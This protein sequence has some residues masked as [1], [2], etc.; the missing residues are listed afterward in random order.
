MSFKKDS[1]GLTKD[2][3]AASLI[4]LKN[5]RIEVAVTD[6]GASLVAIKVPD[7]EGVLTDI[8]LGYD[9]AEGYDSNAAFFGAVI[10]RN[11]NRIALGRYE[12][13]G[14]PYQ[15]AIN[16]N[17][18]NLHSGPNGFDKRLWEIADLADSHVTFSLE[19]NDM[20]Q[21]FPGIFKTTVTYSL[22]E[23]TLLLHYEA[24]CD[25]DTVCNPTNHVY[26]NL[27]GHSSGLITGHELTLCADFYTPVIDFQAIPTGEKA[28]VAGTVFDF[29]KPHLIGE[30]ID[31]PD[32]QLHFVKG[33]DHNYM[34]REHSGLKPAAAVYCEKTGI[35][36]EIETDLP[37]IQL[38][39]GN[40]IPEN[41]AGKNGTVYQPRFGLCLETQYVPN[42]INMDGF[43][44]PL[45]KRGALFSS[46][47]LYRFLV[48]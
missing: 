15:L 40:C 22:S 3:M 2:G 31:A 5:D 38:Y 45:L 36:M 8:V 37:A 29:T 41:M 4:T 26:L 12:I 43:D 14:K 46:D 42:A 20:E 48:R 34:L 30:R 13:S 27:G 18:N 19:D 6:F 9:S 21:G 23:N 32:P 25:Q 39:T 1:F 16:D 28:P 11:A 35:A 17:D 7:R 44:K 10:G 47:T 24:A 33:Y